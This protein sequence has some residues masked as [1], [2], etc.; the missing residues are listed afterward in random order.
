M[1]YLIYH[2]MT[3]YKYGYFNEC[4]NKYAIYL[5]FY[6]IYNY[7]STCAGAFSRPCEC[8]ATGSLSQQCDKYYGGCECKGL[9]V[10]RRCD[11]CAPAAFGFSSGGCQRCDC[12][13]EGSQDEFCNQVKKSSSLIL[14]SYDGL[15]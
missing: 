14:G 12:H 8:S 10:G 2:A 7:I 5:S 13:F 15:F 11:G 1:F 3:L 9:V 6:E 4:M